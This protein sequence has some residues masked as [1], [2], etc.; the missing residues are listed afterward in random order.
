MKHATPQLL[1]LL[2][3]LQRNR[4]YSALLIRSEMEGFAVFKTRGVLLLSEHD[5]APRS[6]SLAGLWYC[7]AKRLVLV[8]F[9]FSRSFFWLS[10]CFNYG[11][12]F[13][14][15]FDCGVFFVVF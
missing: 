5:P 13:R 2:L 8:G 15:G 4:R 1:V 6:L 9:P 14:C 12:V 10:V 11:Y 3:E 7:S